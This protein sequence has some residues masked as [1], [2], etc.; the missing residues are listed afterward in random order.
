MAAKGRKLSAWPA[1]Y[2]PAGEH[3]FLPQEIDFVLQHFSL[4]AAPG[5]EGK[6]ISPRPAGLPARPPR[7]IPPRSGSVPDQSPGQC[8][9]HLLRG[10]VHLLLQRGH[11]HLGH[12][13]LLLLLGQ[14]TGGCPVLLL[15]V[16]RL[17]AQVAQP[18]LGG[19]GLPEETPQ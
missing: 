10:T 11:L 8:P 6:G 12:H 2:L 4:P 1:T 5:T 7:T 9:A 3:K 18:L 19:A 14:G 15:P 16:L 17:S 13:Q